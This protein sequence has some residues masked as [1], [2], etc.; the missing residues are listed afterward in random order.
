MFCSGNHHIIGYENKRY[1]RVYQ[2]HVPFHAWGVNN[3]EEAGSAARVVRVR[4]SF[5]S[6]PTAAQLLLSSIFAASVDNFLSHGPFLVLTTT[7]R[8]SELILLLWHDEDLGHVVMSLFCCFYGHLKS[9][10]HPILLDNLTLTIPGDFP[11]RCECVCVSNPVP[12]HVC[13]HVC[14]YVCVCLWMIVLFVGTIGM[15]RCVMKTNELLSIL[16]ACLWL[17]MKERKRR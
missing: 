17:C 7:H 8:S 9:C 4:P 3:E 12:R 16:R 15:M 13:Q 6:H 1:E 5:L 10:Q 2:D 11:R 14:G